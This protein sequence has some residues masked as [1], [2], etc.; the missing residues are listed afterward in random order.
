MNRRFGGENASITS[1]P[2]SLRTG[3]STS[4][5]S[6]SRESLD[7]YADINHHQQQH[8]RQLSASSSN[9]TAIMT[10]NL[11]VE[12]RQA[13]YEAQPKGTI[14]SERDYCRRRLINYYNYCL[15]LMELY[16]NI[17][18]LIGDYF[19]SKRRELCRCSVVFF[20]LLYRCS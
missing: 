17:N 2:T 9:P 14:L 11:L 20:I 8:H 18:G 19:A 16:W 6:S 3:G 7:D 4:V 5:A 12:I 1:T 13:V 15:F 10:Q